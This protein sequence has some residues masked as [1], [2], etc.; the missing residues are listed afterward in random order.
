MLMSILTDIHKYLC[1]FSNI[2]DIWPAESLLLRMYNVCDI[3][4]KESRTLLTYKMLMRA[5]VYNYGSLRRYKTIK[6]VQC[7]NALFYSRTKFNVSPLTDRRADYSTWTV[8]VYRRRCLLEAWYTIKEILKTTTATTRQ[9][10]TKA[11][12]VTAVTRT[13]LIKKLLAIY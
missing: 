1:M 5:H 4:S 2:D 12:I 6:V 9:I 11:A 10:S 7:K 13:T 8:T 3:W